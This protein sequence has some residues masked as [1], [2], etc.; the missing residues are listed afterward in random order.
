MSDEP[1]IIRCANCGI[2]WRLHAVLGCSEWDFED[3]ADNNSETVER[4]LGSY[5]DREQ[6]R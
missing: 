6:R 3:P 2:S 1:K 5:Y 4:L